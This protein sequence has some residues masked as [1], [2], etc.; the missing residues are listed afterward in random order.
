[1]KYS[2]E[3][4]INCDFYGGDMDYNIESYKS[5]V[6]R[7]RKPHKCMGGC[8]TTINPGEHALLETGFVDGQPISFYTCIPCLDSWIEEI[9]GEECGDYTPHNDA[10]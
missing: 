5:R 7:C 10:E 9:K 1:M 6:V 4:Y 3:D 8:N 2:I